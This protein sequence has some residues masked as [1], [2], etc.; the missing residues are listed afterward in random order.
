M[1]REISR[2][3]AR[4]LAGQ[5]LTLPERLRRLDELSA[6]SRDEASVDELLTEWRDQFP[7]A[8]AFQQRLAQLGVEEA[9]CRR[10]IR[11]DR[12]AESATL[13]EWVERLDALVADTV[14]EQST[15]V[16]ATREQLQWDD[17]TSVMFPALSA[18]LAAVAVDRLP[19]RVR[20]RLPSG[21][22]QEAAQW[23]RER[24]HRRF[25]RV[26]FVEFKTFVAAHD[27]DRAFA[28]PE[29]F[30][31]PP[32]EYYDQYHTFLF[33]Q[34]GF[35]DVCVEY[36]V[37]G[38]LLATQLEQWVSYLTEVVDRVDADREAL[39]ERFG[40]G[41]LGELTE[42]EPM[43]DDTHGDGRAVAK[44][45]F[46][47]GTQIVYKPRSVT[48]GVRFYELLTD[49]NDHLDL[50]S[51]VA[52]TYLDC[53]SYG[54]ME[55]VADEDCADEAAVG[56]YYERA[57]ALIAVAYLTEFTDCHH[58]NVVANG[59]HPVLVDAE[60]VFHPRF[61]PG[62]RPVSVGVTDE[63]RESVVLSSLV[64]RE[65]GD[66]DDDAFGVAAAGIPLDAESTTVSAM[67]VPRLEAVG[68]DVVAV[69]EESGTVEVEANVP[70]VDGEP[71]LPG[72]YTDEIL[73]GFQTAYRTLVE[74][75]D[76]GEFDYEERF[77][78]VENR[79]VYR[80][81]MQYARLLDGLKSSQTLSEGVRVDITL[82]ELAASACRG[83]PDDPM[84]EIVA[85]ERDA[86]LRFDPP[87]FETS[88][89]ETALR[90]DGEPIGASVSESGVVAAR[91]R[92]REAGPSDL[93]AQ[94]EYVRGAFDGPL[95][96]DRRHDPPP[97]PSVPGTAVRREAA[98]TAWRRID[99]AAEWADGVPYWK[100]IGPWGDD[101]TLS[102][103][104][105]DG[106]L[107][108]GRPG[109]ALLPAALYRV[110][111][112][113]EFR[114]ATRAVL[115]PV[116]DR[117]ETI[118][119]EGTEALGG[120]D[121]AGAVA[122]GLAAAGALLDDDDLLDEAERALTGLSA[123][124]VT[125]DQVYDVVGGSA[126]TVLGCLGA[127][128]RTG[129][130]AFLSWARECGDRLVTAQHN[131]DPAGAAWDTGGDD[132]PLVG[133][134]HGSSGV[135]YALGR[136]AAATGVDRYETAVDDALRYEAA[137]YDSDRE[138]WPDLRGGEPSFS[139][140]WCHG[141]AGIALARLGTDAAVGGDTVE[142][143]VDRAVNVTREPTTGMDHLCCGAAGAVE[144]LIEARRR[145]RD[146][147]PPGPTVGRLVER[148]DDENGP[149]TLSQTRHVRDPSLFHGLAGV[150]YTVLRSAFP[151]QVPSVLLWE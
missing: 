59:E 57:G 139:D 100:W 149:V 45:S 17:D 116:R 144:T 126:G 53:G 82:A 63:Q 123:E 97:E 90:R 119:G 87:R 96:D 25:D 103:Q 99:D 33:D 92:L 147:P 56:R 12:F 43:A 70:R 89:G 133:F 38:R 55:W 73:T 117:V 67:T 85:A 54:W 66:D 106:S 114:S 140:Q 1:T 137:V 130:E 125:T 28:N 101:E 138:N 81:T 51:F 107:Y 68:S 122:Y 88:V 109:I 49:L 37:F 113:E 27:E 151:E 76:S 95:V 61:T 143:A 71:A 124:A 131:V 79:F 35:G 83:Q 50:P 8:A 6:G 41:E 104:Q 24:F 7:E 21:V 102:V 46:D 4:L 108:F 64:P 121:G 15:T 13:P 120:T 136:L 112:D 18:R 93:A 72:E 5:A 91:D 145:G 2:D 10:A 14:G 52:P 40:D 31:D 110:T 32:T 60:T 19:E 22:V 69:V 129:K 80:P 23:F 75:A 141:R 86:L 62:E 148:I 16:S 118:V 47:C 78:G 39:A 105:P 142:R 150:G 26:L 128:D 30:D 3:H 65:V 58:E 98:V 94:T 29:A 44:L 9:D 111:G 84:L 134:S 74:V 146:V 77:A 34:R 42:I 115:T 36:P 135:G 127:Y 20:E 11:A 132:T 48:A